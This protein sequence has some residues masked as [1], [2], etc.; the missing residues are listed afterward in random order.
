M[1]GK[2]APRY[3]SPFEIME[4]IRPVTYRLE[5]PAHLDKIHNVFHVSLLQKMKVEPPV[6]IKVREDLTLKTKPVK[7]VDRSEKVL[8]NKRVPLVSVLWRNSQIKEE[9]WER[10]S[11]IKKKYP[12]LFPG[13]GML[14][15]F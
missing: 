2:R 5:L 12:H 6:L 13:T 9:T 11:K 10:E 14:F 1:K 4:R 7:I 15:E 8:R 3:I